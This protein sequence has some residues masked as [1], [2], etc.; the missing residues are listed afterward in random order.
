MSYQSFIQSKRRSVQSYGFEVDERDVNQRLFDWQRRV[1]AWSA[2]RGR[3]AIFAECGLGKSGMQLEFSRLVHE[4]TQKPVVIHCPVGVRHQTKAEACKFD[5]KCDVEV[6]DDQ[7]QVIDGINLVNY[8]KLH[9]FDA[10]IWGG[11]VID[12][13]GI[14]K[15]FQG[16]TKRLL[17]ETYAQ[18]PFRLA[19]TATPAPNDHKEL[20]N[21]AEFLGVMPSNEMLS[22]WFINDTMKAGGYRL[23]GHVIRDFWHWVSQWAICASKPS[24]IGGSDEGYI[25]PELIVSRHLVQADEAV[26]TDGFLFNVSGISATNIHEEKRLTNSARSRKAAE[27]AYST[28][29]P[30]LIWCQTDYEADQLKHDISEAVDVRGGTKDKEQLLLAFANG[31]YRVLITKP[32]IAGF[33]LNYQ[34]CNHMIFA[35]LSYSFE[36]YYQAVRRCWRFG[37]TKPV[38]VDVIVADSDAAIESA[39]ARKESDHLLMQSAMA[40][41][42]RQY[43]ISMANDLER[44]EY[45]AERT[46]ELPSFLRRE[47]CTS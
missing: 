15:A 4:H 47:L 40:E 45:Q 30:V 19:C 22:R 3:A 10:S 25:L 24:D 31:E 12:E 11:V 20:G 5:I 39:V 27:L 21:H 6:V 18:T 8:E 13:S 26:W 36:S 34:H 37:Q 16:K 29:E 9:K 1:V 14:L 42:V 28:N 32:E 2:N 33:G 23:K 46:I 41:A 43:G 7:S 44:A 38:T 35:G 17:I